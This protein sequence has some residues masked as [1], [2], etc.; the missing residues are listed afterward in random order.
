LFQPYFATGDRHIG[1][2]LVVV[3]RLIQANGGQVEVISSLGEGSTFTV[4]LPIDELK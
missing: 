4:M 2:G 1:L 3:K